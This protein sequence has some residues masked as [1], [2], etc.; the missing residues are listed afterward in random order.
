[1]LQE[2]SFRKIPLIS[3]AVTVLEN[4]HLKTQEV[5][6][7]KGMSHPVFLRDD[8]MIMT[9]QYV[10]QQLKRII[11]SVN[12]KQTAAQ[13]RHGINNELVLL[14]YLT[15]HILRHTFATRALEEGI[16]PKVV[17]EILGHSSITMTLD[18]YTH[19][20]P[21]TKAREMQKLEGIFDRKQIFTGE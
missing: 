10:R 3:Q 1:M 21:Q 7:I 13:K 15:P 12:H 6:H 14:P 2:S 18:L 8:G 17:Q 16:P 11:N 9:A 20:M 4:E 19:V 5:Q